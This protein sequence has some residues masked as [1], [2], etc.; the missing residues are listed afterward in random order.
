MYKRQAFR[1]TTLD[2]T[3][4]YSQFRDDVDHFARALLAL[5]VKKGDKVAVWATNVPQWYITFWATVK[6]GA[7]LVTVNTSYKIHEAEYLLRQ[8]DTHT[9]VM[10]DGFKDSDYVGIIKEICPELETLKHG[11]PLHSRKP[12][13]YTHLLRQSL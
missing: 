3:R 2:Y 9:L 13:S 5:G 8:S 7:V 1:F 12:V 4:T 10:I 11:M 6:I